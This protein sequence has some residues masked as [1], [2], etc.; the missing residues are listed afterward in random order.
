M[1]EK[2]HCENGSESGFRVSGVFSDN[3][4]IQRGEPLRVWGFAEGNCEGMRVCG[5]F[6]GTAA[7]T[8]VRDGRWKLVFDKLF[9]AD[10][11]G[12]ELRVYADVKE[13]VLENILVGDVF[14]VAGQS[15]AAYTTGE[16]WSFHPEDDY[17]CSAKNVTPA[18]PIRLCYTS[19][20]MMNGVTRRGTLDVAEDIDPGCG[21]W[22][23]N[24]VK[25]A[26]RFSAVGY[27]F[28][29][30]YFERTG[31]NVPV[32]MVE[33][34]AN[35]RPLGCFL[36]NDVARK[37]NVP[38]PDN[39]QYPHEEGVL[40]CGGLNGEWCCF[41]YNEY[42]YPFRELAVKALLWYQGES[43]LPDAQADIYDAAFKD[44]VARMRSTHNL[45]NRDFPV[46]FI[47]FPPIYTQPEGYDGEQP[48]GFLP[49]GKIRAIMGGMILEGNGIYQAQSSD[50][51]NDRSFWNNLHP[52]CKYPQAKRA[53]EIM[54]AIEGVP[55]YAFDDVSGPMPLSVQ[56]TPDGRGA[57]IKYK[58]AGKG[59]R[60]S[61][62]AAEVRGFRAV[63]AENHLT[64]G[65][66][67]AEITSDDTVTVRAAEELAGISYNAGDSD[68][69]GEELNLINGAS[70]PAGAFWVRL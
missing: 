55:G 5:E 42:M 54:C 25:A 37:Y 1:T 39:P 22:T 52:H 36:P 65:K 3:M 53:A 64:G 21:G 28:A 26:A 57:V 12:A 38:V 70:M 27:I 18:T 2:T 6:K 16:Y 32:G 63:D 59:L 8:F 49:I 10:S 58:Y 46:I 9:E 51:W 35:G 44:L 29:T 33:F 40:R 41:M 34:D 24:T 61:D 14:I 67:S 48:W 7:E 68:T 20:N 45:V 13:I 30:E 31:G 11:T 56:K 62:G 19:Q 4:V 50:L 66:L 17:L 60:T 43:D 47:E 15:N 23:Q 69:F